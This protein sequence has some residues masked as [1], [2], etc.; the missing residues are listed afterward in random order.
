MSGKSCERLVVLFTDGNM[1]IDVA[2][3]NKTISD[4]GVKLMVVDF[5]GPSSPYETKSLKALACATGGQYVFIRSVIVNS[6]HF[7]IKC[8]LYHQLHIINLISSTL[9]HQFHIINFTSSTSHHQLD[10][11]NFTPSPSHH[12]L[13]IINFTPS[14]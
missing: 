12:Q 7:S 5:R 2:E 9:H 13:H 6:I 10:I 1:D 8:S 3:V 11:I 14:T 4:M